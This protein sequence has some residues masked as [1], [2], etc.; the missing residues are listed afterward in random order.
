MTAHPF[1]ELLAGEHPSVET[2]K[3]EMFDLHTLKGELGR[4]IE[5]LEYA[6]EKRQA[7][8]I[9]R[10]REEEISN[11]K[12]DVDD[13]PICLEPILFGARN[14]ITVLTCCGKFMCF[15]CDKRRLKECPLCRQPFPEKDELIGNMLLKHAETKPL[16]QYIVGKEYLDGKRWGVSRSNDRKG[17]K[18]IKMAAESGVS[19][20]QAI[21]G[22]LCDNVYCRKN[23][24]EESK[25]EAFRWYELAASNGCIIIL[26]HL[27]LLQYEYLASRH[28]SI[29]LLF[30]VL[31]PLRAV[32]PPAL[33]RRSHF[34]V[35]SQRESCSG[36]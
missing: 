11:G 5:A 18:Y 15:L 22:Q 9:V 8:D 2:L 36:L 26:F 19:E 16:F 28:S 30:R 14:A 24:V 21:M 7:H 3:T 32:V 33:L 17:V 27:R 1:P 31:L 4:A 23:I 6:R 29:L 20:A 35:L 34:S 12:E 25:A 13:C 10:A